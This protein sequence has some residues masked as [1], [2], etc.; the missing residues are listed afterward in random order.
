MSKNTRFRYEEAAMERALQDMDKGMGLREAARKHSVPRST[1]HGKRTGIYPLQRKMGPQSYLT[2]DEEKRLVDWMISMAKAGFPVSKEDL[3]NSVKRLVAELDRD[4]PF[5]DGRPGRSWCTS[6][7][8]RHPG[9]S[10]RTP[11][12]L[13]SVRA[14]VS[15]E[16]ISTWFQEVQLYIQ[17][18]NLDSVLLDPKRVFNADETA[19]FLNPKGNKI[20]AQKGQK[21]VYQVVNAD[22]KECLTV[23]ITGNAN[24]DVS[25]PLICFKY[26]RIPQDL[27]AEMPNKWGIG[28]SANGWMTGEVF[29]E[30]I[31]NV[32]HPWL[33]ESGIQLPIALFIDGHSSHLTLHT[34][35]FCQKNGIILIALLPNATHIL[36][37]MDVGVFKPLKGEWKTTVHN[38][39]MQQLQEKK[40]HTLRKKDFGKLLE[41]AIEKSVSSKNLSSAFRKCGLFPFDASAVNVETDVQS[42]LTQTTLRI[43]K[44]SQ[45][46]NLQCCNKYQCLLLELTKIF[47]QGKIDEFE[48]AG[49]IWVGDPSDKN[50]FIL[51]KNIK[52]DQNPSESESNTN[53]MSFASRPA[54]CSIRTPIANVVFDPDSSSSSN[55]LQPSINIED[56]DLSDK[57]LNSSS[58]LP[59]PRAHNVQTLSPT[60]TADPSI[61]ARLEFPTPSTPKSSESGLSSSTPIP[62]NVPS[63]FK[64]VLFW[65][66]PSS[67]PASKRQKKEK[68]PTVATSEAWVTYHSNKE[69]L[70]IQQLKMKEERAAERQRKKQE[71]RLNL[72]KKR[73]FIVSESSEEECDDPAVPEDDSVSEESSDGEEQDL[74]FITEKNIQPGAYILGNFPGGKRGTTMYR[75]VCIVQSVEA[76]DVK[77]MGMR[78]T[79][80]SKRTFIVKEQDI[81]FI[82]KAQVLGVLPAPTMSTYGARVRY[83][84]TGRVP[85]F[86]V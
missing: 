50:L 65:P 9:L 1:L 59:M 47:G 8:K 7:L 62:E 11:E 74:Q 5:T 23:L 82:K 43:P 30:F 48:S 45:P 67:R 75:Y 61:I 53:D 29:F 64:R 20:L 26:E 38:W 13:T 10:F 35:E 15:Q 83:T 36:Q 3:Q 71:K 52:N 68:V 70:K 66:G 19:F 84:F 27:V 78:S 40:D 79:D 22:D 46:Q 60:A 42:V 54:T 2:Q 14:Q 77:V 41:A 12:N 39:R 80:S 55:V 25:P 34:S 51:W 85:V 4:V 72:V 58:L 21:K 73:G 49:D 76:D 17:E 57:N 81:S 37:P 69:K 31:S 28:K 86:E 56:H 63:P 16:K 24:G 32:F 18:N 6:F 44:P 33:L